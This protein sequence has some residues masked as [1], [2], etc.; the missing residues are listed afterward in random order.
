MVFKLKTESII[1]R[2]VV[3]FLIATFLFLFLF[4]VSYFISYSN[5]NIIKN[6]GNIINIS[7]SE[8]ELL[9]NISSC[10]PDVLLIASDKLDIS[11][12]RLRLLEEEFGKTDVRVLEQKKIYS[13]LMFKHFLLVKKENLYC[14]QGFATII[15]FYSN[16]GELEKESER[17]GFIL[18]R[19]KANYPN[20]V[21]IYSFDYDLDY[22]IINKLKEEYSINSAPLVLI[23]EG[24]LLYVGNIDDLENIVFEANKQ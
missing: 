17:M 1:F 23:N 14:E 7:I 18:S 11:S 10:E 8:I 9:G 4:F 3:A 24:L 13:N 20:K 15:F 21:M 22:D 19:F 5:Y 6:Q 2:F 16:I 12:S